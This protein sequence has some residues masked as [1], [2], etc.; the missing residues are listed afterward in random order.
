[1]KTSKLVLIIVAVC[2]IVVGIFISATA[3]IINGFNWKD[4]DFDFAN[5]IDI[6]FTPKQNTYTVNDDFK[7]I[8][9]MGVEADITL[10]PANDN[11]CK[12][13]CDESEK[14]YH[15]VEVL[16]DTLTIKRKDT[17]KWY[18]RIISFDFGKMAVTVYLP[19]D[20]YENLYALTLSGS[21]NILSNFSFKNA[22]V[23]NTSGNT[24]F[25]ANTSDDVTITAVSGTVNAS[26]FECNNLTIETVSGEMNVQN[27]NAK[28][29]IGANAVS[30]DISLNNI[31]CK[32]IKTSAVS[33]DVEFKNVIANGDIYI[34]TVSGDIDLANSDGTYLNIATTSGDVKGTLLSDKVFFTDTTSGEIDVPR[35]T[36][37][38]K[39]EIETVSGDVYFYIAG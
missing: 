8:Y 9:I 1:M 10:I 27:I 12:V 36:A 25:F 29:N 39:C 34:D 24:G 22:E 37:D 28:N 5:L 3:L 19:K 15:T 11:S 23:Y 20:E 30:G 16:D 38:E 32:N 18:E 31:E 17:K 35:T 14:I 33:G 4:G 26:S 13:V 7:N 6:N 2:L 21:I